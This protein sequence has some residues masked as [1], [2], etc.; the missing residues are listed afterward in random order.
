M[1]ARGIT[2]AMTR[3]EVAKRVT[4]RDRL[5]LSDAWPNRL[6][7]RAQ[8]T[9]VRHAHDTAAGD[10][11]R[12]YDSARSGRTHELTRTPHEIDAAVARQPGPRWRLEPPY[13]DRSSVQ[14]PGPS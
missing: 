1:Q 8:P 7:R 11:T 4:G 5:A 10:R 14:G 6:V 12:E 9:G 2:A 13:H 3:V